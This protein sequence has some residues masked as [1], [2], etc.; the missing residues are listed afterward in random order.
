M[1]FNSDVKEF[2]KRLDLLLK[3]AMNL[4]KQIILAGNIKINVLVNYSRIINLI[5]ILKSLGIKHLI[6]VP[7]RIGKTTESETAIDTMF[8]N[9]SH[10]VTNV[11]GVITELSDYDGQLLQ[12]LYSSID[13]PN[14]TSKSVRVLRRNFIV[15]NIK[16]FGILL[17]QEEWSDVFFAPVKDKFTVFYPIFKNYFNLA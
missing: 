9:L 10:D 12:G 13:N 2:F 7:S 4:G 14:T 8:T 15:N 17:A 3:I 6:H 5:Y 11:I 1:S 16:Y